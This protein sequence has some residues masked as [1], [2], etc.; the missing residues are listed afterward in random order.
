MHQETM[1]FTRKRK[2]STPRIMELHVGVKEFGK[3]CMPS[4][5]QNVVHS[6]IFSMK[7]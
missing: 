7:H 2:V 3:Q 5:Q 4:L 6:S 1:T